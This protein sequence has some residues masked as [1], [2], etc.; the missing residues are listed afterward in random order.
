MKVSTLQRISEKCL[1]IIEEPLK[2]AFQKTKTMKQLREELGFQF[3]NY[4][5]AILALDCTFQPTMEN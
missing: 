4:P 5:D 3:H 1:S 2:Q